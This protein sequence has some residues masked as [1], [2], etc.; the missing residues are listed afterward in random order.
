MKTSYTAEFTNLTKYS[1]ELSDITII[2]DVCYGKL[3]PHHVVK[4]GL[5]DS[6]T[7]GAYNTLKITVINKDTGIIDTLDIIIAD[8]LVSKS[9]E[10][11]YYFTCTK[12]HVLFTNTINHFITEADYKA[13]AEQIDSYLKLFL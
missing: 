12:E 9:Y 11:K 1:T 2:N 13:I 4:I 8:L 5:H 6:Y 7:R 10:Y 3:R